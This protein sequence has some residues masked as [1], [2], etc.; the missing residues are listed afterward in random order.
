LINTIESVGGRLISLERLLEGLD[1]TVERA[2]SRDEVS[3]CSRGDGTSR[4]GAL[5]TGSA[6]TVALGGGVTMSVSAGSLTVSPAERPREKKGLAIIGHARIR[7]APIRQRPDELLGCGRIRVTY[8]G[9]LGLFEHLREPIVI[10]LG[11][12]DPIRRCCD[13]LADETSTQGAGWHSMV[14]TLLRRL[15]I[16][17]LRRSFEA[18]ER[19]VLWLVELEDAHLARAVAAMRDRPE[20]PFTL[21][22]L[23][24]L[25]GMSRSVFAARFAEALGRSPMEFL[26]T[27]RLVRAAQLLMRTDLP[28]KAI[29]ARVGYLSRSSFTRAFLA[30]HRMG[31]TEF[32]SAGL[33]PVAPH[34]EHRS[35]GERRSGASYRPN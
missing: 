32:R 15:F 35:G 25:A 19:R 9:T 11:K 10:G 12:H 22:G 13:D 18:G 31:P 26:K 2:P 6:N 1:V 21:P 16:L 7:S 34:P 14:E 30:R 8:Q 23:A 20:H 27:L 33:E 5:T 3:L 17:I 4:A 24:E 29:A 28:V